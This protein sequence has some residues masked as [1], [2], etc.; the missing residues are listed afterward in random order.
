MLCL[1]S[2]LQIQSL[3]RALSKELKK[4]LKMNTR[5]LVL[6]RLI[7]TES[8][9]LVLNESEAISGDNR[10]N[11]EQGE[12]LWS[13]KDTPW[14]LLELL[15]VMYFSSLTVLGYPCTTC[16]IPSV[17]LCHQPPPYSSLAPKTLQKR[18]RGFWST[19]MRSSSAWML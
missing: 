12:L 6:K 4:E 19:A 16:L 10:S 13:W 5:F 11:S 8:G 14:D 9:F 7:L 18:T 15:L 3:V 17:L 1:L 2:L